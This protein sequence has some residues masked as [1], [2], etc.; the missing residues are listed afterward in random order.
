MEAI[1]ISE[2]NEKLTIALREGNHGDV[3]KWDFIIRNLVDFRVK[4]KHKDRAQ[5]AFAAAA[6]ERAV[7]SYGR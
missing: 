4:C 3:Q 6:R 2:A 7:I 5:R 1:T